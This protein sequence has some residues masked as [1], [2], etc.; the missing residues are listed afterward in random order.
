MAPWPHAILV[1][2]VK[3]FRQSNQDP[4]NVYLNASTWYH[5]ICQICLKIVFQR[6][7]WCLFSVVHAR[8]YL[9]Y[10]DS[11]MSV[12]IYK[13]VMPHGRQDKGWFIIIPHYSQCV[14]RY[15]RKVQGISSSTNDFTT[16]HN[17][18]RYTKSD[19]RIKLFEVG[20]NCY[21]EITEV[22]AYFLLSASETDEVNQ[23]NLR[24]LFC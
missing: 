2:A 11:I 5:S 23:Y 13:T 8:G 21:K 6:I 7:T 19:R 3:Q 12:F 16:R 17:P 1:K 20:P 24:S 10:L 18:G 14:G 22:P 15:Y 9:L 4:H